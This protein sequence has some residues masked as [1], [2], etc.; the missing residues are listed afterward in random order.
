MLWISTGIWKGENS[1]DKDAWEKE[2]DAVINAG[3]RN[4][5]PDKQDGFK[6]AC[7]SMKAKN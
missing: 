7:S 2:C 4:E 1:V 6:D 3:N 5:Y